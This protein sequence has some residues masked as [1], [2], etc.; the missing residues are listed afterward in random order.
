MQDPFPKTE[1]DLYIGVNFPLGAQ[2]LK[3][4]LVVVIKIIFQSA[5]HF[6]M[7]VKL[8]V[9][10]HFWQVTKIELCR[11]GRINMGKPCFNYNSLE[12]S[13]PS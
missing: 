5:V 2:L 12:L 13:F 8:S 3:P 9:S 11:F 4:Q 10:N 7:P 6:N 1:K